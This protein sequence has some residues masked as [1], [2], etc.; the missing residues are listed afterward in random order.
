[1]SDKTITI[2]TTVEIE[3]RNVSS[4][5]TETVNNV[6]SGS[7]TL[8]A[9]IAATAGSAGVMTLAEG[10][11]LTDADVVMVT[12]AAGRRYNC[13]LSST[14]STSTTVGSGAGDSLPTVGAVVIAKQL[15]IDAAVL[16]TNV[17]F[18][19]LKSDVDALITLETDAAVQLVKD[20]EAG[21][22]FIWRESSQEANPIT[23]DAITKAHCYSKGV[24]AGNIAIE[25][26]YD[27]A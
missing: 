14:G 12:W 18:L 21:D 26:G 16:G 17:D 27:N 9:G 24:V 5:G 23:G 22:T 6:L 20:I 2:R 13:T 4:V 11:G 8:L 3:G 25:I 19:M 7:G 1:M 10:H 15:E